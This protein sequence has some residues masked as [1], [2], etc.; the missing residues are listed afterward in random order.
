[1]PKRDSAIEITDIKFFDR[2]YIMSVPLK[3]I[4]HEMKLN[5]L[6]LTKMNNNHN[7]IMYNCTFFIYYTD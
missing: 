2:K 6:T 7:D 5:S 3:D 4:C 1:M